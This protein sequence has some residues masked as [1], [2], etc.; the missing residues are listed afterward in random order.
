M[1]LNIKALSR[2]TISV[3]A[4]ITIVTVWG[5]LVPSVKSGIASVGGHHWTG[6]SILS[7]IVFIALYCL[8]KKMLKGK[9]NPEKE[10]WMIIGTAVIGTA[11][12]LAFFLWHYFTL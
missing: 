8:F 2:S 10:V 4:L 7:V 1:K 11:V 12:L 3:I 6:K 9:T 5:E